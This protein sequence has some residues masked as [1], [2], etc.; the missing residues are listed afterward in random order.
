M[1]RLEQRTTG[2]IDVRIPNVARMFDYLLA[3]RDN[4]PADREAAEQLVRIEPSLRVFARHSHRFTQRVVEMLCREYGVRQFIDFGSGLPTEDN[5][6]EVAR[7]TLPDARVV[8]VETDPIVLAHGRALLEQD[9]CTAVLSA[10]I[11]DVDAIF[12]SDQVTRLIDPSEPVGALFM[13]VLHCIPEADDPA[14]LLRRVRARLPRGSF[15]A[16]C[17]LVSDEAAIRHSVTD[18]MTEATGGN[19]G[20]VRTRDDVRRFLADLE[21]IPPGLVD[22]SAWRPDTALPPHALPT[23]GLPPQGPPAEQATDGCREFGGVARLS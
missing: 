2:T 15:L 1:E 9:P 3:G 22:I 6:H 8:Y 14:G 16:L 18:I 10:D 4:Y 7:R 13:S 17:Q 21:P 19:W 11:R 23:Q 12:A 20:R 5:V